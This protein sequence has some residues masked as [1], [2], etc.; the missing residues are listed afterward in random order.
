[1]KKRRL[2]TVLGLA[3]AMATSPLGSYREAGAYVNP[4]QLVAGVDYNKPN[5][6][7]SPVLTKFIDSLPLLGSGTPSTLNGYYIPVAVPDKATFSG[8]DY[9]VIAVVEYTQQMHRELSPTRLRGYVQIEDPQSNAGVPAGSLHVALQDANGANILYNG[10]QVYGYDHPRYLGPIIQA[11]QG[12]ATRIK[13]YNLL[14][15]TAQGGNLFLPTDTTIMG[16]GQ[17]PNGANY[18]QNRATLHLH[19]GDNPWISDGTPHQWITPMGEAGTLLKGVSQRNVPDMPVPPSGAATFYWLNGQCGR[20]M[21]YHDHSYG[22]TR[23]NVYAGEAAGYLLTDPSERAINSL[24]G[25]TEI[26]LVIQDK[27]FVSDGTSPAAF[28]GLGTATAATSLVDPLWTANPSWGQSKGSLW[29][30]HVYMPNQNPNDLSGANP[31]GRWDYGAWFWPIF[32]S[33]I[34]P[35][36]SS[37][38][39][40]F[41]DTPVVNG[42]AYPYLNVDPKAYRFRVLNAS[43]DRYLNL[44]L[45]VADPTATGAGAGKEVK[46][47]PAVKGTADLTGNFPAAGAYDAAPGAPVY[48]PSW[49]IANDTPGM[50]PNVLD[51]RQSGVPD[52]SPSLMGPDIIHI[53]SEGGIAPAPVTLQN[54]PM[55]YEQNKRSVTVL[56]TMEHTLFLG[57]AERA[58]VVVDFSQYAGKT[59]ILY[60]DAPAPVPAGDPRNDYYTGNPDLQSMGGAPSTVAGFGPNIRTVMQIRVSGTVG[61]NGTAFDPATLE[62]PMATAFAATQAKP[63]VPETAYAAAVGAPP[64]GTDTYSRISDTSLTFTPYGASA[65]VVKPLE[66]KTIQELFDPLG[67][68]NSTLGVEMPFTTSLVQTTIPLGYIDPATEVIPDGG[69]QLWK[70]THNGVD[71]HAIHFHLFNVQLINRVGWDGAIKPPWPEE[72]GWKE[73]VKMNPLEDV[74]VALKAKV[75]SVP[76]KVLSSK[77]LLDPTMPVGST[78][79]FANVTPTNNPVT[80]TNLLTNFGNEY[81]WHCHLLGHEE[82]DMMRPILVAAAPDTPTNLT[83]SYNGSAMVL[84]WQNVDPGITNFTVQ[85]ATNSSFTTGLVQFTVPRASGTTN[86]YSDTTFKQNVIPNY[87]RVF[88]TGTVGSSVTGYPSQTVTTAYSNVLGPPTTAVTL[89]SVTQAAAPGSPVVLNWSST[90]ALPPLF[91]IQRATN[92][93]FTTGLTTVTAGQTQ[94]SYSFPANS[95]TAGKT[96]YFR[97]LPANVFG[98]GTPTS[99]GSIQPHA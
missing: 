23:L 47:I 58:D 67:R 77:R 35:Q 62:A 24:I 6:A 75:P 83:G 2:L 46:T 22:T 12:T 16:A 29:F 98:N 64:S 15:T 65:P 48:W 18:P 32:P 97:I 20:L 96:Y 89:N 7:N 84:T 74:V 19:G 99:T 9:Y 66:P 54:T 86:T 53:G 87:Y 68:M 70:I 56:N 45:Y 4:P 30:P 91:R 78:M 13:F 85:R 57:P 43:N 52:P 81:V 17:G 10:K 71:T 3:L 31:M 8:T 93:A 26:P 69:T 14:P 90:G 61:A 79:G 50:T 73:T 51:N 49:W 92:S 40:S 11:N 55:G 28:A 88:G 27:T 94:T 80:V 60:N 1:M 72:V 36:T 44:Q 39:E 82:N 34:P 63:I 95:M 41:M 5:Y 25:G 76:F 42:A 38:P 33:G 37:V 21:F 59:L